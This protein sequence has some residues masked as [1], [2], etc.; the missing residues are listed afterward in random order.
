MPGRSAAERALSQAR[1][2]AASSAAA[3]DAN[4]K[5][6]AE[7]RTRLQAAEAA[8]AEAE[9]AR[10][11]RDAERSRK[12]ALEAKIVNVMKDYRKLTHDA[13]VAEV[14]AKLEPFFKPDPKMIKTR[15]EDLISREYLER[16][17][18]DMRM[19]KYLA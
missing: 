2:E 15:I 8:R 13:L 17:P 4:A 16:D 19:Y 3:A 6:V 10:T 11:I 14:T 9:A 7:L 12:H 18:K 5:G 1:A